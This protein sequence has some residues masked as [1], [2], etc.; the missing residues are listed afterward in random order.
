MDFSFERRLSIFQYPVPHFWY[1][2]RKLDCMVTYLKSLEL[3]TNETMHGFQGGTA[4]LL[5]MLGASKDDIARHIGWYS[6]AMVDHYTQA[7][8]V[9][10]AADTSDRLAVSTL[11]EAGHIR[12]EVLGTRFSACNNLVDFEPFFKNVL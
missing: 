6:T 8:K 5:S 3:Y 1:P 11:P 4:I 12:A 7:D 9:L 2:R 10:A